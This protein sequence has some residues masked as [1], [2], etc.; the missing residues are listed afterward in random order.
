MKDEKDANTKKSRSKR[1]TAM[2]DEYDFSGGIR[3]KYAD[4]YSQGVNVV[5][6]EPD[7]VE[8][9]PD[10]KAVNEALRGLLA[11]ATRANQGKRN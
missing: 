8:A 10:S 4:Q 1:T 2:K 9:F 5:L 11:I 6:L 3:G 7:L